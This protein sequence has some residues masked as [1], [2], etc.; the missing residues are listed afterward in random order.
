MDDFHLLALTRNLRIKLF[1]TLLQKTFI[2]KD[3]NTVS[4]TQRLVMK[5]IVSFLLS[6]VPLAVHGAEPTWE[7]VFHLI[8]CAIMLVILAERIRAV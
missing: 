4:F 8:L 5:K 7:L 6:P 3:K 2:F 1:I